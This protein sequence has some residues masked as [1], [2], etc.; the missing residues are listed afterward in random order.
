MNI[1]SDEAT[2]AGVDLVSAPRFSAAWRA[3]ELPS[4]AT[5][6]CPVEDKILFTI[7]MP[8]SPRPMNPIWTEMRPKLHF[9]MK[10]ISNHVNMHSLP[11]QC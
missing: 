5:T 2:L 1:P 3:C 11:F 4:Q 7:L 6:S 10:R 8:R 9:L